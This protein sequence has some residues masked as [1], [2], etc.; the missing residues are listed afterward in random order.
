VATNRVPIL[1]PNKGDNILDS[2]S[3]NCHTFPKLKKRKTV[4]TIIVG[5]ITADQIILA[6]D[7]QTTFGTQKQLNTDKISVVKFERGCAL[8]AESGDAEL[9]QK[10]VALFKSKAEEHVME[11]ATDAI[12]L[13]EQAVKE[14]RKEQVDLYGAGNFT[15]EEWQR[16]FRDNKPFELMV[17]YYFNEKPF[18]YTLHISS[19][20]ACKVQSHYSTIGC[21]SNLGGYLLSELSYPKMDNEMAAAIAV[22]IVESVKKHDAFCGGNTKIALLNM[23]PGPQEPRFLLPATLPVP[24]LT[25]YAPDHRIFSPRDVDKF[26]RIVSEM[27]AKTKKE[28][29]KIIQQSFQKEAKKF[30]RDLMPSQRSKRIKK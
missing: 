16:E 12:S 23:Q 10:A 4:V 13:A 14:V 5:I 3:L 17:A 25:Y 18:L 30:F 19:A 1:T 11:N 24:L 22:Y 9:S 21:G 29:V 20:I 27:D 8:V 28:R 6:S 7:S 15:L 2:P 26:V